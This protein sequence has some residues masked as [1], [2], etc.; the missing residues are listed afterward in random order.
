MKNKMFNN[1]E[2]SNR[3][4]EKILKEFEEEIKIAI[5]KTKGKNDEDYEQTIKIEILRTLSKNR[6]N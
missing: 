6:K 4:I 2:L 5:R 1:F 3:E